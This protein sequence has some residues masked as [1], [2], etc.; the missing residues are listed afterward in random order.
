MILWV[1]DNMG[2]EGHPLCR[3]GVAV[4]KAKAAPEADKPNDRT[5][6]D[7]QNKQQKTISLG[8]IRGGQR[9]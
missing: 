7:R 5:P 2:V 6:K 3:N 4:A 9:Q 1:K 8:V